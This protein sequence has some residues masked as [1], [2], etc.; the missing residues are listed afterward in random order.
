[1]DEERDIEMN[2]NYTNTLTP[3]EFNALRT[4]VG[5]GAIE[6]SSAAKGLEHTA[7]VVS[8]R[9]GEKAVGMARA[10]TDYGYVVYISDVVVLPEYQG[11]GIGRE[12]MSRIM[13]YVDKNTA[14]GQEKLTVLVAAQGKE[15][16]YEKLGF[17]RRPAEG[18]G[19]GMSLQIKKEAEDTP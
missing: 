18:M 11:Q 6:S 1:M 10:I 17:I 5:W 16:F 9:D 8:A 7:L 19:C 2:I 3:E 13:A 12:L 14:P 15:E 4:A